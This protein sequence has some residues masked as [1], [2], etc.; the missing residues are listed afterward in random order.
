MR[1]V[2]DV[3]R[4]KAGAYQPEPAPVVAK[5]EEVP[6]KVAEGRER[7]LLHDLRA[8]Y[9]SL[10]SEYS[11]WREKHRDIAKYMQ[12]YRF[13]D[14]AAGD[15]NRGDSKMENILNTRPMLAW[16]MLEQGI[17]GG[18][19]DPARPW[20]HLALETERRGDAQR[21]AQVRESQ[22]AK[23][24]LEDLEAAEAEAFARSN[25]YEGLDAVYGD[26]PFGQGV[27]LIEEDVEDG[28]RAYHFPVGT[29]V[30]ATGARGDVDTLG[31]KVSLTVRQV[32]RMFGYESCS[33]STRQHYDAKRYGERVDVVHF[34]CPNEDYET[35]AAG[36]HGFKYASY[37]WECTSAQCFLRVSGYRVKPFQAARWSVLGEDAYG[38]GPGWVALPDVKALQSL[39]RA[40]AT[41]VARQSNP[42]MVGSTALKNNPVNLAPGSINYADALGSGPPLQPTYVVN[43]QAVATLAA[44][45]REHED[46][47]DKCFYAHL[48]LLISQSE[49]TKKTATEVDM[50]RE[51]KMQ[52]LG[53]VWQRMQRE[54][55]NPLFDRLFDILWHTGAIRPPPQEIQGL[56]FKPEYI[57]SLAQAQKAVA[58]T[59]LQ[60]VAQSALSVA[61]VVPE[62]VDKVDWDAWLEEI[63]DSTGSPSR[64]LRAAKV[65]DSIRQQRAA[66]QQQQAQAEA[67]AKNA[68]AVRDL[69]QAKLEDDNALT[70]MLQGMGAA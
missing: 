70:Q 54:L 16:Q 26:F 42:S 46:R 14:T 63:S 13:R 20:F 35:G 6:V 33:E 17:A 22:E 12:P 65:V 4:A 11:W 67:M 61:S 51:E 60:R 57:S 62:V 19:S 37:W 50:L 34:I 43:P 1:T 2:R 9:E 7:E 53:I 56:A 41:L 10:E 25:L 3:V 55:L 38:R 44:E 27:Q 52:Q 24:W 40:K 28:V 5:Q 45:L 49:Q 47:I 23:L 64:V 66:A 8:R 39:E 31:R 29:Y 59:G 48:W 21:L 68:G 32:V 36:M 69:S 58:I 15:T 30:L 18:V